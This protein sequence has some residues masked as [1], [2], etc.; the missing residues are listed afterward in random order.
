MAQTAKQQP[1]RRVNPLRAGVSGGVSVALVAALWLLF[2]P[3]T[4]GGK[5]S[6]YFVVGNSMEPRITAN[7]LVFLRAHD[8]YD[9]GDVIGYRDPD[10]GTVVHRIRA[11]DGD[12]YVTRGDNRDS[13]D[14]Y[15]PFRNDVLGR[16]WY[17]L[18]NG[19]RYMR[20]LQSP[21]SAMALT[22]ITV[23]YGMVSAKP[24]ASRRLRG[25]LA[26]RA[27]EWMG[28]LS[29]QSM[30]GDSLVTLSST[31]LFTAVGLAGV[32]IWNGSERVV[33]RDILLDQRG[34]L[35]YTAN[36]GTGLYDKDRV[37]TGQPIF[38]QI[39]TQMP[40][41]FTYEITPASKDATVGGV[42]G[43]VSLSVELA[44]DNRWKR[45]FEILP[46]TPFAGTVATAQ[47][48]VDLK[49]L[50]ETAQRM[51][52]A[53]LL[54]YPLYAVRIVAEVK[55]NSNVTGRAQDF[56]YRAVYPFELQ[57]LQLIPGQEFRA[58]SETPLNVK[59][60]AVEPW[61]TT[62]PVIGTRLDYTT[63]QIMT[64]VLGIAGAGALG[65]VYFSTM[66]A[67]RGGETSLILAR[68]APLLVSVQAADV[69]FGGRIVAVQK[70]EDLAR[71]ARADG[72]FVVHAENGVA[73][74]FLLVTAEV[75]YLYSVPRLPEKYRFD[76]VVKPSPNEVLASLA[77]P[78]SRPGVPAAALAGAGLRG[79]AA[80]TPRG[81]SS[82]A[83]GV[84]APA[85]PG[86]SASSAQAAAA[87][88]TERPSRPGRL[89]GRKPAT[90]PASVAP[91]TE[92]PDNTAA[93]PAPPL[94]PAAT[95]PASSP[96]TG[97]R[98]LASAPTPKPV[99]RLTPPSPA[100]APPP[101]AAPEAST[102]S[103]PTTPAPAKNG[104]VP[105]RRE[106][107]APPAGG[108]ALV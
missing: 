52:Q 39:G 47:G 45:E 1:K 65:L 32:M 60:D 86:S 106:P 19:A 66:L 10:L 79:S 49:R 95:E 38:T 14:P 28:R 57:D 90:Q 15:R 103:T 71:M 27:P 101:A 83:A 36:A 104:K 73:D 98:P 17:V 77:R 2:A 91:A 24:A 94:A 85:T 22:V 87:P 41:A 11:L 88:A 26:K 69:D 40:V 50:Q 76:E 78:D 63:L 8:R 35:E 80:T 44:Q 61:S 34:Q 21:K 74:H 67:A 93:A 72:L 96:I 62:I 89:F 108:K 92:S 51:E 16:E 30:T 4:M 12:R 33:T 43:M 29:F 25:R 99:T 100:P 6:Y 53:A 58:V 64:L 84:T 75:T 107:P 18:D 81:A 82:P 70:F 97:A 68:Y 13:D 9:V 31:L 105:P 5:F 3:V 55:G 20:T 48:T 7:D 59:R 46:P 54:K 23:A 37:T 56:S 102:P 42:R